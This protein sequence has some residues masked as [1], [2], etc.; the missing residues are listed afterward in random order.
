M[1]S[2]SL[3]PIIAASSVGTLIEW[4]DFYIFG[5]LATIIST[6]FFPKENATAAFLATL[7]TFA[8]GLVVRPFGALFFGRL[9]DLI[10]RKYT[11]MVTL[12]LMGGSTFAIGLI[13][14]YETIGFA[15]PIIIL[16]L[17]ILQGLAI[18]GEYGGAATFVA[19]H[20]PEKKR[21]FW[22]SWIQT[23]SGIAFIFSIGAI[24]ITKSF[25]QTAAWESWGW[26]IPFLVSALLVIISVYVRKNM[27]ESPLYARA[28]A[29]GKTST[30]PLKE[31][32][33]NKANLKVVLLALFGLTI[34]V[35]VISWGS[36]FYAQS[37]LIRTMS[38]DYDQSNSIVVM[39]TVMGLPFCVLFG[40]LS[41]KVGRK[42][43]LLLSM[44]LGII[45]F[46]P[47]FQHMY[48]VT[49]LQHKTENKAALHVVITD[50]ILQKNESLITTTTE[51]SYTDG[52]VL[53]EMKKETASAGKII[54]SGISKTIIINGSDK[55]TLILMVF[56]L[57]VISVLSYG[58]L[59]A[60]LVEMFPLKIRY[61]SLSLPY[62][63]GFGIFGGMAP[64][65]ATYLIQKA[66]DAYKPGYYLAGLT[67]PIVVMIVSLVIGL[68]YLK[69]NKKQL[70]LVMTAFSS[71]I[72]KLKRGL[73]IVWILLGLVAAFFG[74]FELGLPNIMS[75]KQDDLIFGL[76][77]MLIIT[78][79]ASIGLV[80]FGRYALQGAYDDE[81]IPD[82][83]PF[84]KDLIELNE[85]H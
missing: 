55:W 27:S 21:G 50:R 37:F 14:N 9:G 19:E 38:V 81:I 61:S 63:I 4:Y 18:G 70:P 2:K 68:L 31:S 29:E 25:M 11:F 7:A 30:N 58:P 48:Q 45:C 71:K 15:A 66:S 60:F 33:G 46:R 26:R 13:P 24:I 40:W 51:H 44:L 12:V 41:D 5:T 80:M 76:I 23:S 10:G 32:F 22:T 74:V 16:V 77:M 78:P 36:I 3:V 67:Y 83:V 84:E 17:R 56:V 35:G 73:G 85:D 75:G 43:L 1:K 59:A 42:Y 47:V 34:G 49:N 20:S 53:R 28:K 62:H 39:G 64:L 79:V 72:N 54:N 57:A 65:I 52:T 6:Q 8:A 69:E 82:P